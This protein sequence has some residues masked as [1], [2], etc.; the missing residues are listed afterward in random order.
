MAAAG[1]AATKTVF[2]ATRKI[3]TSRP[4]PAKKSWADSLILTTCRKETH[5][6]NLNP[7]LES[8]QQQD[9]LGP[10]PSAAVCHISAD[11]FEHKNQAGK[12]L[13]VYSLVEFIYRLES[14]E[15]RSCNTRCCGSML[16]V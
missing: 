10:E 5:A 16:M 2:M 12:V 14:L 13:R 15:C 11:R 8:Y 7:K 9:R 6:L 3:A 4:R 1:A